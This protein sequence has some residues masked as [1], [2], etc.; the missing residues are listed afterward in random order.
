M[1]FFSDS[2]FEDE[3][4]DGFFV[5]SIMKKC[6]AAQLEILSD[7]DRVCKRYNIR[8]YADCGTLLGAVRHGGFVPWDDDLD[9]C[10]FR[11]D[12]HRFLSVASRELTNI[13]PEYKI[14]N[15]H[16]GEYWEPISRIV[17]ADNVAFSD[18][19]L[20]KFHGYPLAAGIDIFPLDFVCPDEDEENARKDLFKAIL[21]LADSDYAETIDRSKLEELANTVGKKYDDTQSAKLQ[22]YE[23][24]E[25]VS[26]LYRREEADNVCLMHF[27]YKNN[28][29]IYPMELFD[30]IVEIPFENIMINA[31]AGYDQ[32]LK[33]E[34]GDYMKLV[35][36][37]GIHEYPHY[38][39]QIITVQE[40]L[41]DTSPFRKSIMKNSMS[42][43]MRAGKTD[44]PRAMVVEKSLETVKLLQE[45]EAELGKM[46]D[47]GLSDEIIEL[48]SQCQDVAIQIGTYIE[49]YMG[50]GFITVK[51][52]ED[53]C[54]S[55]YQLSQIII[56]SVDFKEEEVKS[57]TQ[58]MLSG[59]NERLVLI[60]NS[61]NNDINDVKEVVIMP[62]K[63]D[64]WRILEGIWKKMKD[65]PSVHV[66]V[67]PI[68]Y[69]TKSA[70]GRIETKHFE[71]GD[72]PDYITLTDYNSYDFQKRHPYKIVIQYPYD[73]DNFVTTIDPCFYAQNLKHYTDELVYIP[74]FKTEEIGS[75]EERAYKVMG[76]Y[77]LSPGVI[78]SD[79][80]IVQSESIRDLYIKKLIE[81]FGEETESI[82]MNKIDGTGTYLYEDG[83]KVAKESIDMP[84]TWKET[85]FM[86]DGS[87][88]KIIIY[89]TSISGLFE[90]KNKT[91]E[92]M[93]TVFDIFESNSDDV[94]VIWCPD[95]LID[96]TIPTTNP[97][98]YGIYRSLVDD[99][100]LKNYGIY[101]DSGDVDR[102]LMLADAY[103]GDT[104]KLVQECRNRK[105]PVMIQNVD[106]I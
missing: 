16:D 25:I 92:K 72:Y 32:V 96:A 20:E 2:Y 27:W 88:K 31:P 53:Y 34:Y 48:L 41:G 100:R 82:W 30:K 90:H 103:Y 54:E 80:V 40:W 58:E 9:I 98:L 44:N 95:P 1:L 85:I 15:Y 79:K 61:I 86:D 6:W 12:Y 39:E 24:G 10:M 28:D 5:S 46:F 64:C 65:D 3:V 4:R 70:V 62:F 56:D 83:C 97:E 59:L 42:E 106:V 52:L 11:D 101:D 38:E 69:Y 29:H 19:R 37:G 81:F 49:E 93:K 33:I 78:Y 104:D 45:A 87:A 43:M 17:N 75:G 76:D 84:K 68:P 50:D 13:W 22:L 67:I 74:Y 36:T 55:V 18:V 60:D 71:T 66:I 73:N 91:L 89:R 21:E 94:V 99:F 105:I 26:S 35:R 51:H 102:L 77:V 63:A 47:K 8:W 57:A 14:L 7:I 23:W